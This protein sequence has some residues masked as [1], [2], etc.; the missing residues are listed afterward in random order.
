MRR[1]KIKKLIVL[2]VTVVL[3]TCM[4]VVT[5]FGA[6]TLIG[7]V[8]YKVVG[9]YADVVGWNGTIPS[10][11]VIPRY[12]GIAFIEVDEI[13][14]GAFENCTYISSVEIPSGVY[15]AQKVFKNCKYLKTATF[16]SK[17]AD[18]GYRWG[19]GSEMFSECTSLVTVTLPTDITNIGSQA[20]YKC[21]SL[22]NISI[23]DSIS[24]IG[25]EAFR[26]CSSIKSINI[27]AGISIGDKAFYGCSSLQSV[28]IPS[29]VTVGESVFYKCT[30]LKEV[31]LAANIKVN[32]SMFAY[33]N[34][35]ETV[36][37]PD[38]ITEI[39]SSAFSNCK[40]LK[41]ITIPSSVTSIGSSAFKNC[42][43]LESIT[44]P[45]G[46][47]IGADAFFG[48]TNLKEVTITGDVDIGNNAF[49]DCKSLTTI[50]IPGSATLGSSA[51]EGCAGLVT[52]N[53]GEGITTIPSR[54][55]YKCDSVNSI[56]LPTSVRN[57]VADA[58][59][60][61]GNVYYCGTDVQYEN[62]TTNSGV[63]HHKYEGPTCT[64]KAVCKLCGAAGAAAHGHKYSNAC[65]KT[66][67]ECSYTRTVPAH[68]YS[69]ACDKYCNVC[70]YQ[71]TVPDHKYTNKCDTTCNVCNYKRTITHTYKS[72]TTKAT[73]K[74]DGKVVKTC[75]VCGYVGSTT[76][77]KIPKTFKLASDKYAYDG[78]VKA[79]AVTVKDSAGKTLKKGTDYT[80]MYSAGRKNIG[81]YKVTVK[82][83]GKY[84]GTK[85]LS[86]KIVPTLKTS[87]NV[88]TKSTVNLGVKSNKAI[89][90]TS[91]NK[92]VATVNA[93]GV[94]TGIKAGTATI[95][96][97]SAGTV[98]KIT[99]KV[100]NPYISISGATS[101]LRGNMAQMTAY[102]NVPGLK[103]TWSVNNTK[104]AAIS[105]KGVFL[106]IK[107]GTVTVTAK[108]TYKGVVYKDTQKVNVYALAPNVTFVLVQ[109]SNYTDEYSVGLINYGRK[110]IKILKKGVVASD[111]ETANV[112]RLYKE[113]TSKYCETITIGANSSN[114]ITYT[115]DKD[116]FFLDDEAVFVRVYFEYDGERYIA[117]CRSD[118]ADD[119]K[120][121]KLEV[122]S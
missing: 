48:C 5:T 101:L 115:L 117:Y 41:N 91:S 92:K 17:T 51:F 23:P 96:V 30:D 8:Y 89:T 63:T 114:V 113:A 26:N 104:V 35:L 62:I 31:T 79:P 121:Y 102:S 33:C 77:I 66:C 100:S 108:M 55:F 85:T 64:T 61:V 81:T 94:V 53:I 58:F 4:L 119:Q 34:A 49:K 15:V 69:N 37:I 107:R 88:V 7:G 57:I 65:D 44:I 95:T 20:F 93:K 45:E 110:P 29:G 28:T 116:L 112:K 24:S 36:T 75:T 11:L 22:K 43:S 98:S 74:K 27:P 68:K 122:I 46:A 76:A 90:Y 78:K 71:R 72:T 18:Y 87:V 111:G 70:N 25:S 10:N 38:G 84:S 83:K 39:G 103:V 14:I 120:C 21:S 106:G 80:V 9:D 1:S 13:K 47:S 3:L 40:N 32:S 105:T 109:E 56:V 99:V 86:F 54:A 52:V 42:T 6:E 60:G 67:N 82:M 16:P 19:I 73:L 50:S 2:L 118:R 59:Y 97:K 12:I